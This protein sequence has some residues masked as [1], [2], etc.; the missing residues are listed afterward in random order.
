MQYEIN[1]VHLELSTLCNARCTL[2]PRNFLGYPHNAGYP[3]T[4]LTLKDFKR[5]FSI[6]RLK[7]IHIAIINGNF[8]DAVMNPETPDIVAYMKYANPDMQI[9]LHTNGGARDKEFWTALG[10]QW[11]TG[12]FALDGL[13]DTHSLYRQD[14]VFDHVIRNAKTFMNA[15]G[16]GIW[17]VNV[18]DHNRHQLPEI[19][20]M[21]KELGFMFVDERHTP[22]NEGPAY[23]RKGRKV[24]VMKSDWYYPDQVDQNFIS[25]QIDKVETERE[26]FIDPEFK[27]IDCWAK[28]ERSVY[29]SATG[30][31][32]PCC[33]TGHYPHSFYNHT[34]VSLWNEEL[35][36]YVQRNH[37]PTV[38]LDAAIAWFDDFSAS[39]H[40]PGQPQVCKV[41]CT[42]NDNTYSQSSF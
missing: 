32:F 6:S 13:A 24:F 16:H 18:F 31:V 41:W 38:G 2:C 19:H 27:Q 3:E 11:I 21:A 15:G 8:G 22:R 5:I 37:G 20:A 1:H 4:N 28:R 34:S 14:T 30:H 36:K 35:C 40:S 7:K 42:K 10:K 25:Q 26:R 9:R 33:W 12:V 23:D 39:W 29:V 17:I